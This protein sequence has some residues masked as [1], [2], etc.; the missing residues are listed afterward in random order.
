[1]PDEESLCFLKWIEGYWMQGIQK[2][3]Y[4]LPRQDL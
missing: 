3:M 2:F 4:V 1:M